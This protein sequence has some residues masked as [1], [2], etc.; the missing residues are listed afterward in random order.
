MASLLRDIRRITL[1]TR[2]SMR[3]LHPTLQLLQTLGTFFSSQGR[4]LKRYFVAVRAP[5]GQISVVLPENTESK[6]DSG[7]VPTSILYPR[8]I[9]TS[10]LSMEISE[11]KR[12]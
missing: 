12:V 8:E 2:T 10:P 1:S 6:A 7:A 11:L 9:I 5:T 3:A 4:A